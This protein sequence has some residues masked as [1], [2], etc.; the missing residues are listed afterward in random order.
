MNKKSL[1]VILSGLKQ[2]Q[3]PNSSLEQYQTDS[4]TASLILWKAYMSN[5]IQRKFIADLGCGN[6]I[7]GVGA[8]ILG[9]KKVYFVE[10]DKKSI[11]V[12]KENL[13]EFDGNYEILNIDIKDF[14]LKV[15]TVIQNPPFGVQKVHSDKIFLEKAFK[16]SNKIYTIH[17][18]ESQEFMKSISQDNNFKINGILKLNFP[19]K[20]TMHFHRKKKYNVNV[21]CWIL[22]RISY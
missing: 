6:G 3:N 7:F 2:V 14:N 20:K 18:I 16:I 1:A 11:K 5:D 15:D 8:I 13:S 17:K 22:E 19:L 10:Q 21:G 4:E 9:A 12:L